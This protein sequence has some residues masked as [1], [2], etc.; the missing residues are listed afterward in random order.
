M[1]AVSKTAESKDLEGSTPSPSALY[2]DEFVWRP[3]GAAQ[4]LNEAIGIPEGSRILVGRT[5]L[6][7]WLPARGGGFESLAFR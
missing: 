1:A 3:P 2:L 5:T 4:A 6:L 7:K